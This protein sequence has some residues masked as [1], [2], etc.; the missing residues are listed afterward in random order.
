MRICL[1]SQEYPPATSS[2]G[3]GTQAHAK[4]HGLAR[5][6]HEV[7]VISASM[8]HR[9]HEYSDGPVL[10]VRI[11]GYR[12]RMPLF[13]MPVKWLTYSA[14]VA[15]E[16]SELHARTPLDLVEFA[17]YGAEGYIHL[18]NRTEWNYIPTV[19]HL[20]GPLVMFAHTMGWPEVESEFYRIGTMM[21]E[22]CLRLANGVYSSSG[23]SADWCAEHYGIARE[24]IPVLHVGVD[25][26]LFALRDVPKNSRPTIIFVGLISRN[27]GAELLLDAAC[28]LAA[29]FPDLQLRMLGHGDAKT[30]AILQ[31]KALAAGLPEL[32][33]CPGYVTRQELFTQLWRAHVFAAPSVY[34]GGPSFVCLEAMAC[35]LPVI[36]SKGSGVAEVITDGRDGILVPPQDRDSLARALSQLLSDQARRLEI[37]A[38]ARAR[39]LAEA[40]REACLDK[41]EALYAGV[42]VC[43]REVGPVV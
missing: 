34:E 19:I 37:G 30:V 20:H 18:L 8:D 12:D 11:P 15:A 36:A 31:H 40:S 16:I 2:G 21:E 10:T 22:K 29:E 41:I 25:T 42:A 24:H 13:S 1:V 6:G 33:D 43:H 9:R 39:V 26:E 38:R 27:K 17:E 4:A 14:E 23:C 28:V 5:R 7:C 35:G 3:I 32:L